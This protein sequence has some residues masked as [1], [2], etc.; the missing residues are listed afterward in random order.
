MDVGSL[1]LMYVPFL[2]FMLIGFVVAIDAWIRHSRR[3]RAR[4][5]PGLQLVAGVL[6]ALVAVV[7]IVVAPDVGLF[8]DMDSMI[9]TTRSTT[10]VYL[11]GAVI[12]AVTLLTGLAAPANPQPRRGMTTLALV[13]D[14]LA[15]AGCCYYL[16]APT[17]GL[18]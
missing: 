15:I 4:W 7:A 18:A 3:S 1:A 6:M 13:L 12:A 16:Y 17:S 8:D 9:I 10:Q 5:A 14:L 2:L 11:A